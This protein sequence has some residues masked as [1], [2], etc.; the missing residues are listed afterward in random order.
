[1]LDP[2]GLRAMTDFLLPLTTVLTPNLPEAEVLLGHPVK[3]AQDMPDTAVAL[4]N[5]GPRAVLDQGGS[6]P[7]RTISRPSV[8]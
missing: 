5:L 7:R 6:S 2:D 4:G 1:M 3:E 8:V